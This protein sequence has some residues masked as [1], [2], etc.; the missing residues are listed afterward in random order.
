MV[1]GE[2]T[3]RDP[4][5]PG[6]AEEKGPTTTLGLVGG[7]IGVCGS[8]W[9]FLC[10]LQLLGESFKAMGGKGAGS[11]F[12]GL[13][14]PIAGLMVGVLATVLVQSS[15]TSTSI[16]VGLVGAGQLSVENAIPIIMG[17]NI[18]TSVTNTIVSMG[19]AGDRVDLQRAFSA[20]TVHDCFNLLSVMTLLPLEVIIQAIQ[21]Q[22]GPLFWLTD[23]LTILLMGGEQSGEVFDSPIKLITKP[24]QEIFL[25]NNKYVI[26]AL[27]LGAPAPIPAEAVDAAVCEPLANASRRLGSPRAL[28]GRRLE[29]ASGDLQDC[30]SVFC[31]G[32]DMDGYFKKLSKSGYKKLVHCEGYVTA[33]AS[34]CAEADKCYINAGEYYQHHV[35]EHEVIKGGLLHPL[36]DTWGGLVALAIA[37]LLLILGLFMVTKLLHWLFSGKA[38]KCIVAA[39]KLNN[40][41][42][43]LVGLGMTL[44]A[45]SSSVV[46]SALTPFAALGLIT[47]EKML[48]LTLGANIGTCCTAIIAALTVFKFNA[49]HIALCHLFFNI[50]GIL[51]WYPVPF[52]R[53]FIIFGAT[54]L[55]LYASEFRATPLIYVFVVFI[56]IPSVAIGVSTLMDRSLVLGG[57]IGAAIVVGFIAFSIWWSKAGCYRLLS[58]ERRIEI[59][60]ELKDADRKMRGVDEEVSEDE[61]STDTADDEDGDD[62]DES[63]ADRRMC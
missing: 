19:F 24:V 28:L 42:A 41:L 14:N 49:V 4:E 39:T 48:P 32:E 54:T 2:P 18:G 23:W 47:L 1:D 44:V 8:L 22:G 34:P 3:T 62:E 31:I 29:E 15:S 59:A 20:A 40:Y 63:D 57:L 51:I 38:K 35:Q 46:T 55:G 33:P 61:D 37:L 21:G 30:S 5:E 9:I 25:K 53:S 6:K 11:I 36:G 7:F 60:S 52:M 17:S 56:A 13:D 16:V 27:S 43:M 10:G 58:K 45:Q 26:Y 50:F 12:S